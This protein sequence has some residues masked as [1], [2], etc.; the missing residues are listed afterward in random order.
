MDSNNGKQLSPWKAPSR[1]SLKRIRHKIN[2]DLSVQTLSSSTIIEKNSQKQNV[3]RNRLVI[4]K[5]ALARSISTTVDENLT[6]LI[7]EKTHNDEHLLARLHQ[8]MPPPPPSTTNNKNLN[9]NYKSFSFD[10]TFQNSESNK[11]SDEIVSLFPIDWSLK[12]SCRFY[13]LNSSPFLNNFM[14]L[15]STDES[16]AL[17][18]IC[19]NISQ[20]NE[21]ALFRSLTSYWIYPHI[22]WLRLFPRSQQQ[23]Q[24]NINFSSLDEQAQ[25]ALQ[26]EWK[27]TFQSLFQSFRTKYSTFF[28]MCTHTFN[29]LFREDTLSQIIAIIS[30]TTSGLRSTLEREGIEF[31]MADGGGSLN[32]SAN[33]NNDEEDDENGDEND[34]TCAQWLED[35]G[36]STTSS[37]NS[38]NERRCLS[39]NKKILNEKT[40]STTIIIRDLS[41]VNSLFNFL[42]NKS[43]RTCMSLTGPLSGI[44]PTLISPRPFLNST[45]KYLNIHFQSNSM[46]TI[47]GGP[48]LPDRIKGL[49]NLITEKNQQIQMICT[50]V[51]RTSALNLDG[52]QGRTIKQ[53]SINDKRDLRVQFSTV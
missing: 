8:I 29:I 36:L 39:S 14:K 10:D 18:Y 21:K 12:S 46:V 27:I 5:F 30:P 44:P 48:L 11:I 41:S 32:N 1:I 47:D 53:I 40:R 6:S 33:K 20:D 35:M 42:L 31:T 52:E 7:V 26:D 49:W 50:N 45:L 2:S 22:T 51:E 13:S 15:R 23:Q 9:I 4:N 25:T 37:T 3:K 43:Q 38:T 16:L 17:E 28:Y 19:S 24:Q 34:V